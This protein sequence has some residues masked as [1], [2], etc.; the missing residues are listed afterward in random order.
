MSTRDER[1]LLEKEAL[2]VCEPLIFHE[3]LDYI[4]D[5]SDK[6]LKVII[7]SS[8]R[9]NNLNI[10]QALKD[11]SRYLE[12]YAMIEDPSIKNHFILPDSTHRNIDIA[13]YD[14]VVESEDLNG[15]VYCEIDNVPPD[16]IGAVE[17]ML[18]E[19]YNLDR[20]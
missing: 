10:V 1:E 3:L 20:I 18:F 12:T 17:T 9:V 16:K 7:S 6:E 4:D 11:S 2:R 5:V 15:M 14:L 19:I 13:F 8:K